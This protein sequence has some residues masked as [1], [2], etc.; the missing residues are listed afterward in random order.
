M[1]TKHLRFE[2]LALDCSHCSPLSIRGFLFHLQIVTAAHSILRDGLAYLDDSHEWPLHL[3]PFSIHPRSHGTGVRDGS[4]CLRC[5]TRLIRPRCFT[6]GRPKLNSGN[7]PR[8]ASMLVTISF[9]NEVTY[10]VD[11]I[12]NEMWWWFQADRHK[13]RLSL[14]DRQDIVSS[15]PALPPTVHRNYG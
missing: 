11:P 13:V 15:H 6:R 9:A 5:Q 2:R 8:D 14:R 10:A 3:F 1:M 4:R 7:Q 12:L